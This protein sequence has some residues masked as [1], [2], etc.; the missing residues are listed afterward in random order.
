MAGGWAGSSIRSANE[1]GRRASGRLVAEVTAD[2]AA[3]SG[4]LGLEPDDV[5]V[6]GCVVEPARYLDGR[7]RRRWGGGGAIRVGVWLVGLPV[8][9]WW[10][11][12][13]RVGC[14]GWPVR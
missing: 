5:A 12:S 6:A 10:V 7:A 8:T 14:G 4:G 9:G 2:G 11:R 1:R 3:E 13:W